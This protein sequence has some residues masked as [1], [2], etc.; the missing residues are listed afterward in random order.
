L[1]AGF[2]FASTIDPT[3]GAD[4]TVLI[5]LAQ[6]TAG[7]LFFSTGGDR[8]LVKVLADSLRICPPES[9]TLTRGWAE[10]IVRFSSTIFSA[11]LRLAAPIVAL[12]LLAD[13]SLAVLGRMQQQLHLVSLT[14][15][16]KLGATMVLLSLTVAFQPGFFE[17]MMASGVRLMESLLRSAH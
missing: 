5:T 14:M 6:L 16:V 11:G 2:G 3:S 17:S 13:V 1:Q 8:M 15:P 10:P 4:S 12:L 7:L 9:F